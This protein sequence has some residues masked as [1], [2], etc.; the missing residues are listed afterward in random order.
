MVEFITATIFK[1]D[2]KVYSAPKAAVDSYK[3]R[4]TLRNLLSRSRLLDDTEASTVLA[5]MGRVLV[6]DCDGLIVVRT[7]KK[8]KDDLKMLEK[9]H[10]RVTILFRSK[11]CN[12]RV[13]KDL[14]NKGLDLQEFPDYFGTLY[15][16]PDFTEL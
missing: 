13:A 6:F 2:G 15:I 16:H 14:L 11:P 8:T 9:V 3:K 1:Y 5:T 7:S 4:K 12:L 10:D